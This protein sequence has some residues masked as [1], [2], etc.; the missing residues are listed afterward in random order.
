MRTS[1]NSRGIANLW[2]ALAQDIFEKSSEE[3]FAEVA[4]DER[5]PSAYA[6]EFQEIATSAVRTSLTPEPQRL[7]TPG[8]NH[9]FDSHDNE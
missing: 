2:D 3:L 5:D 8:N 4:E 1:I 9:R 7:A 6:L